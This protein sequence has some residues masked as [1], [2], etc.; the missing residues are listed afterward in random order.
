[1]CEEFRLN[2]R[3]DCILR[4]VHQVNA[5]RSDDFLLFF[6]KCCSTLTYLFCTLVCLC[7]ISVIQQMQLVF[8]CCGYAVFILP[9]E[10]MLH[11]CWLFGGATN[12]V[13][14]ASGSCE[15]TTLQAGDLISA[16]MT[17][18][19]ETAPPMTAGQVTAFGPGLT[20][21]VA[22]QPCN[23]TIVTKDAGAGQQNTWILA[24]ENYACYLL[25]IV[26]PLVL[27]H[28]WLCIRKSIRP[29]EI[30]WWGVDV[31]ICL[32]Q[33]ADCLHM[34]QLMRLHPLTP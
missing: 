21:G 10:L 11:V 14:S 6:V 22:G 31:A 16:Q 20:H 26:L 19:V 25:C 28:C 13:V 12:C 18:P 9:Q 30:E 23:F 29:V 15:M 24:I 34:V 1:M 2:N 33:G 17:R 27:W 32:E 7:L 8:G 5:Y 3:F 4:L